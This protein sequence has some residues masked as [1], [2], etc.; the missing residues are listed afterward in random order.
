MPA[1]WPGGDR[2]EGG[3]SPV[4]GPARNVG[5]CRP[6]GA[7]RVLGRRAEGS[8]PSSRNCEGPSTGAGHRGGPSVVAVRPGNAGGA[9]GTG[10][11]GELGGQPGLP[12]GAG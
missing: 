1:D 12:G 7:G 11:P 3:A 9:K 2:R 8:P 5:T 10:R 4:Q 6:D